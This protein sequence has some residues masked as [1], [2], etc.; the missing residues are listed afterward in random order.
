M[1]HPNPLLIQ[2]VPQLKPG[3]CGVTDHAIPLAIELNR[4]FGIET[5]FVVLNSNERCSVPYPVIYSTQDQLLESCLA[6]SHG[7]QAAILV[8]VS[9]YGYSPD[10]APARLADALA[11]VR[12]DGRFEIA[13]FFH[14]VS[15]SGPPW[16]TAFWNAHRQRN[17]VRRIAGLCSLILTSVG[18][19]AEW[20][21]RQMKGAEAVPVHLLPVFS[22]V[23]ETRNRIPI[24]G[25][26]P[27]LVVFGLPATRR[28]AYLEL[29]AQARVLEALGIKEIVDIGG[30]TDAPAQVSGIPVR[31]TGELSVSELADE[32]P[33]AMF[34]FLSYPAVYIAKSSVFA[35]YCSQGTIPVIAAP[36]AG[37]V[38]GLRDGVHLLSPRTLDA[39]IASGL[40]RCSSQAWQW[41][42]GHRVH[43]HAETYARWLSQPALTIEHEETRR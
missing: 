20:L 9:G 43:V 25:R 21:E 31:S 29:T 4:E 32:I 19:H 41:Y 10:G 18:V 13:G 1:R 5:A 27:A 22:T 26:A 14:E 6:H 33:R 40:D 34:G 7:Q 24:A 12:D 36:F 15:A 17:S 39:A 30:G 8:H 38:D 2:V 37:E 35:A 28:R 11:K 23:G 42:S 3:R 16:T